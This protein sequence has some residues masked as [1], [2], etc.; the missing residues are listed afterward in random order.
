MEEPLNRNV[1]SN[2]FS[3][4]S[5]AQGFGLLFYIVFFNII[6]MFP[7]Y[8]VFDGTDYTDVGESIVYVGS[9][10]IVIFIANRKRRSSGFPLGAIPVSL[11]FLILLMVPAWIIV[12]EPVINLIPVPEWGRRLFEGMLPVSFLRIA[13]IVV[14]APIFEELLFRGVILNGFLK[15]YSPMKAILL[16]SFLFGLIHLNPWQFITAFGLGLMLGWLY[17]KTGSLLP[18]IF[19]HY[20]NNALATVAN[21]ETGPFVSFETH[22]ND[23]VTYGAVFALSCLILVTG[24]FLS[25]MV[26]KLQNN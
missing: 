7:V 4:P 5:L 8:A 15:R 1:S 25:R 19:L 12:I 14:A 24:I 3:Y 22:L 17:W 23:P 6:I 18:C 11:Y 2:A 10:L 20:V 21:L 26:I 9:L 16:S 13:M